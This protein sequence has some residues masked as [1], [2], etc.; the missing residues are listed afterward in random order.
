MGLSVP[1][2]Q[3]Q[4]INSTI[5]SIFVKSISV[6]R[7]RVCRNLFICVE[8]FFLTADVFRQIPCVQS[9]KIA[10]QEGIKILI[11]KGCIGDTKMDKQTNILSNTQNLIPVN[12][13]TIGAPEGIYILYLEDYVHTFIKKILSVEDEKPHPEIALYGRSVEES[14]RFRIVV[15]GAA[16]LE[17]GGDRIQQLNNT[18]FPSCAYIGNAKPD[19]NKD[20]KLRI[21][22]TLR[23]TKVILDDFY[24]YYDQNEEMQNYLVE[25]NTMRDH[26]KNKVIL[27]PTEQEPLSRAP[28]KDAA[29]LS[30][31]TQA[32]NRE[33]AKIGFMWNVMNVL[34]LGFVVCIMAYGIISMNNYN[35]MQNMQKNIDYCL[36]FVAEN[37]SLKMTGQEAIPTMQ[38]SVQSEKEAAAQSP[39]DV[40]LTGT[41]SEQQPQDTQSAKTEQPHDSSPTQPQDEPVSEPAQTPQQPAQAAQ[42]PQDTLSAEAAQ[43]TQ[44]PQDTLSAEAEQPSQDMASAVQSDA[45]Q[46]IQTTQSGAAQVLT[47]P[48]QTPSTPQYYV[49]RKGDTLRTICYEIY[50]DYSRVEE[51]CQWNQIENPDNILYGQK[52]LLP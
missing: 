34:C 28:V 13:R 33:E 26:D 47:E 42:Q 36:A 20:L 10:V 15:S 46:E 7:F 32:Y 49:V 17:G 23:S 30:R 29:H 25:W 12:T 31:I 48:E 37:T 38:Q 22:L 39:Q 50:G 3:R 51:I 35:K 52:L 6:K 18:Y 8:R 27:S 21:E 1:T 2:K 40:S 14:G 9:V 4:S 44:Q 45:A 5:K 43:P 11:T 19:Y 16:A 24:I 41:K